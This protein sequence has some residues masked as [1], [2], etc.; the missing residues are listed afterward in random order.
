MPYSAGRPRL[1]KD[2]AILA[3]SRAEAEVRVGREHEPRTP[4]APFT[5]AIKGTDRARGMVWL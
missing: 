2:V 3:L 4:H 5:A 1:A